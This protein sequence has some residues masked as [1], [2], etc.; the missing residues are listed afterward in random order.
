MDEWMS[1]SDLL[2][3]KVID[4]AM[5][6]V[7]AVVLNWIGFVGPTFLFR[8]FVDSASIRIGDGAFLS[9]FIFIFIF[10]LFL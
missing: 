10:I 5:E 3:T 4:D 8:F 1:A 6:R 9:R 2:V 7:V